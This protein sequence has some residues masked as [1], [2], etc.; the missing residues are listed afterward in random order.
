MNHWKKTFCKKRSPNLTFGVDFDLGSVENLIQGGRG[1]RHDLQGEMS[2]DPEAAA[3]RGHGQRF[4][5]EGRLGE[6]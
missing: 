6:G 5:E 1:R 4:V 3:E 2:V